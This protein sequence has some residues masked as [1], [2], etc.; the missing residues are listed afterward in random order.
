MNIVQISLLVNL[1]I[2]G[3]ACIGSSILIW[4]IKLPGKGYKL[5]FLLYTL[6]W[7]PLMLLRENTATMQTG[8]DNL[9]ILWIPLSAYGFVGIFIRPLANIISARVKSRKSFIYFAL[10]IQIV[11]YIPMIACPCSATNIIQSLGVGV[12]ASCIATYQL[13]FDEQYSKSKTFL[14]ISVLSIPPLLADFISSP[15][16]S[17]FRSSNTTDPNILKYLWLI[18][19]AFVL[20]SW[21]I[22]FFVKE[23]RNLVNLYDSKKLQIKTK[24]EISTYVLLVFLGFLIAFIK[25]ANSSSLAVLHIQKLSNNNS[26]PYEG[27]LSLLFSIGQLIGGLLTGLVLIKYTNRL[28]TFGIG[29]IVWVLYHVLAM[30][31]IS[32]FGYL[33]VHILNGLAY[34]IIYNFILGFILMR[35]FKKR[36]FNPM[37]IYQSVLSIG[38]TVSTFFV[39]YLKSNL[40]ILDINQYMGLMQIINAV[41]IGA[42]GLSFF[43]YLSVYLIEK[44]IKPDINKFPKKRI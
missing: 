9:K 30:I 26:G 6:F 33:G 44:N 4:K 14:T 8:L 3:I 21:V 43:T 10:F 5:L 29:S 20:I 39:S 25:F 34:G 27:H 17:L 28:L 24:S 16:T 37:D 35:Q 22:A 11:T 12:G 18:G 23:D 31:I 38:I 32:P 1:L 15:I 40:K 2:F 41:I 7:I 42:V 13:L 19:L 36:T